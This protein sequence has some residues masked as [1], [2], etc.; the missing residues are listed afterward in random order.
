MFSNKCYAVGCYNEADCQAVVAKPSALNPKLAYVSKF[1]GSNTVQSLLTDGEF[2]QT[3]FKSRLLFSSV[4]SSGEFGFLLNLNNPLI[5]GLS[6]FL[7]E[8]LLHCRL[9]RFFVNKKLYQLCFQTM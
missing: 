9:S 8:V 7:C 1:R 4:F 3:F 2:D 5:G 6:L